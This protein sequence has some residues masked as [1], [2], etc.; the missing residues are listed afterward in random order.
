MSYDGSE[1]ITSSLHSLL[2]H[3]QHQIPLMSRHNR[4]VIGYNR[5][6]I[7]HVHIL[8]DHVTVY[9]QA[10]ETHQQSSPAA[11]LPA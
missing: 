4:N 3:V 7:E 1:Y 6:V 10:R 2:A 5:N 11:L 9:Q 8:A